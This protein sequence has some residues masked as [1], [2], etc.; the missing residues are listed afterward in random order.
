M[1]IHKI[2]S[3]PADLAHVHIKINSPHLLSIRDGKQDQQLARVR[4]WVS[5]FVVRLF[6]M[7]LYTPG[8]TRAG[9]ETPSP[10][11][12][13]IHPEVGIQERETPTT[14]DG[15]QWV[16]EIPIQKIK[17]LLKRCLKAAARASQVGGTGER[18]WWLFFSYS[19]IETLKLRTLTSAYFHWCANQ[20][21]HRAMTVHLPPV[22]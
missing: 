13:Q 11:D 6:I 7:H 17:N 5:T 8:K 4:H 20:A 21:M 16:R 3:I 19:I 14:C 22:A 12:F 10:L 1:K 2:W 18:R 9:K 15:K